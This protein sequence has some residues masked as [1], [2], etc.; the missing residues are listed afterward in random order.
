[1]A[2]DLSDSDAPLGA[3][4]FV[5]VSRIIPVDNVLLVDPLHEHKLIF[6]FLWRETELRDKKSSQQEAKRQRGATVVF[7]GP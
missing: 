7:P 3:V 4:R 2:P 1:M 5:L 6:L